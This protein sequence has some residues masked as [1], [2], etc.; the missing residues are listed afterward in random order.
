MMKPPAKWPLTMIFALVIGLAG[1]NANVSDSAEQPA[2]AG[3]DSAP[4]LS[5]EPQTETPEPR[6]LNMQ[7]AAQQANDFARRFYGQVAGAQSGN[8]FFS[9]FSIHAAL[10]MTYAGARGETAEQMREVLAFEYA[11]DEGIEHAAYS[12]L[13]AAL[14]DVPMTTFDTVEDGERTTVERPVFELVVANRLWGQEGFSWNRG[15]T[16]LVEREYHAGLEEV[17]FQTNAEGAR[18]TINDWIEETTRE[19]IKNL[20]PAGAL[21]AMTRLVLTNAIYFKA[22]WQDVFEERATRPEP[23]HLADG[24]TA[25]VPMMHQS[26]TF[27][28]AETTNWQALE[29]AY[30]RNAL[31][32]TVVLPADRDG[33]MSEVEQQLASGE[34]FESLESRQRTKVNV[35][36]PKFRITQDLDLGDTL[37]AMGMS[38]AFSQQ[39]DFSGMTS[40]AELMISKAL[41]KAFVEVDEK[42]TEAAAATAIVMSL[43]SMPAEPEKP[44]VFRADRPFI[45]LIRHNASGAILFAGRVMDPR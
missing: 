14:N 3:I 33:A 32:M 15:Y 30:E 37:Q 29:M 1:C 16:G 7:T 13:L 19:R 25:E 31:S 39:A 2:E 38:R 24:S 45:F 10:S 12:Q 6:E 20:I 22:N 43:T 17:D 36:F 9:P 21:D 42:G 23:F 40:E 41:H 44:K 8:L 34:L 28:Y 18:N 26:E 11:P 4:E 35:W 5:T 27:A